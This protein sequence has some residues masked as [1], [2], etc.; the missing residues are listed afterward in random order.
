[1]L[2]AIAV[3]VGVA[4]AW[5]P[6]RAS[7]PNVDVALLLVLCAALCGLRG[8]RM[9]VAAGALGAGGGFAYFD[10]SPYEHFVISKE[11]DVVT[12]G[13]LVA[14]S[15]VLGDLAVRLAQQ[16]ARLAPDRD[17]MERVRETASLVASGAELV[18]VIGAVAA[19]LTT[20]LGATSAEY[21]A[22]SPA[23]GSWVVDPDAVLAVVDGTGRHR[24][25]APAPTDRL[26]VHVPV[27]GLGTTLGCFE[28]G[29]VDVRR[30]DA[31]RLVLALTLADQVGAALIAQ[32]PETA[33]FPV[34]QAP[35]AAPALRVVE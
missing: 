24:L 12:L 16:R 18:E 14:V 15:L 22:G 19:E 8:R 23:A 7:L 33:S 5:I 35:A 9:L 29:A 28:M 31:S 27:L 25:G 10:T 20:V 26:C 13:F 21:H 30:A 2:A 34:P 17:D 6:L 3:P 1:M 32:A 11:P 4:A